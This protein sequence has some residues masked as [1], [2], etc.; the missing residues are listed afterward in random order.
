MNMKK[1]RSYS[2]VISDKRLVEYLIK[3]PLSDAVLAQEV[4]QLFIQDWT[5]NHSVTA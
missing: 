5:I 1:K 4:L 3:K 2:E